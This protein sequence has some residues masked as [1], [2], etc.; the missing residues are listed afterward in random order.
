MG[1]TYKLVMGITLMILTLTACADKDSVATQKMQSTSTP[2]AESKV[3]L[4]ED[5]EEYYADQKP[6]Q[7][8]EDENVEIEGRKYSYIKYAVTGGKIR[9]ISLWSEDEDLIIPSAIDSKKVCFLGGTD[10]EMPKKLSENGSDKLAWQKDETKKYK[11]IVI[12]EG[13]ERIYDWGFRGVKAEVIELPTTMY[14]TGKYSFIRSEINLVIVKNKQMQISK[15]AFAYSSIKEMQLPSDFE[16]KLKAQ[17]FEYSGLEKFNWPSGSNKDNI[18]LAT[19]SFCENLKT[20]IFPENQDL[21]YIQDF[22]FVGCTSL[23]ELAFPASTKK[24]KY[25]SHPYADNYTKGG[26]ETLRFLGADTELDGCPYARGDSEHEFITV[27]KI[28]APRDSKAHDYAKKAFKIETLSKKL[29]KEASSEISADS[30]SLL[31]NYSEN[32]YEDEVTLTEVEYE[33]QKK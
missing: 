7:Y 1:K 30:M 20:V 33:E 31:F 32:E 29:R 23:E 4:N 2:S 8:V 28:I 17:C 26:V 14:D 10:S 27:G 6:S 24:V 3:L 11:K 25:L 15:Q 13:V 19:F 16:G 18:G 5:G 9:I 21:I 22:T 12:P